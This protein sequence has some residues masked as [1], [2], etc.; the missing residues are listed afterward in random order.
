M[1]LA[2][3]IKLSLWTI[4]IAHVVATIPFSTLIIISRLDGLGRSLEEAA[5]DL[6][7]NAW[8]TFWRVTFPAILPGIVACLLLSFT[9]S[10]DE[11]LF[12]LFLGGN[13][14]TLPVYMWTQVRFPQTLPTVLALGT[15]I[16]LGSIIL[17]TT[18]EFLRRQGAEVRGNP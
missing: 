15:C 6:G 7:E 12:A 13:E 17:M 4:G 9:V 18:A 14:T 10:F 16:F 2:L 11:F 1:A 3:E 8:M 5:M